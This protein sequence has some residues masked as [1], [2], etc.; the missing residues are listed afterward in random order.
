MRTVLVV[1]DSETLRTAV[2]RM[3]EE[4]S[5]QVKVIEATDGQEAL[6]IALSGDVDIV[7]SDIVMPRLD[8]IQLLR[9]IRAQ[10]DWGTLPVI[11]V[12]SQAE[13]DTRNLSFEVGANDYLTRPFG[14]E[15]LIG[16]IK[17][18]LRLRGLHEELKRADDRHRRLGTHDE[19]TGLANRRHLFD[20]ARRELSRA[21]RHELA[22]SVCVLELDD[23]NDVNQ[24]MGRVLSDAIIID[25]SGVLLRNLR[26]ADVL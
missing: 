11:L 4:S 1:D 25:L 15:E 6:P 18:Q 2:R 24:K 23:G 12:T 13:E 14:A 8:G 5:L 26:T 21:R 9:G 17:V 10:R 7:V 19:T 16:R 20:L 3:L 22:M